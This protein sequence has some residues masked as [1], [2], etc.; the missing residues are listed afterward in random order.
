LSGGQKQRVCL[1]RALILRPRLLLLDEPT[2]ALD[3]SVQALILEQLLSLQREFDLAFLFISH[4][5]AV[6]RYMCTRV[7]VMFRG[8]IVE[9]GETRHVLARPAHPYTESL[10]GAT[11]D[12]VPGARLPAAEPVEG[13][14][15]PGGCAYVA[16]CAR[17]LAICSQT[18]PQLTAAW[19]GG[20]VACHAGASG[21]AGRD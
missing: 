17:R 19:H 14:A 12:P 10:L 4:N 18:P 1:A 7:L 3:V 6:V 20:R 8:A 5:L 13:T 2:S 16:R 11:L 21:D 9:E 15:A